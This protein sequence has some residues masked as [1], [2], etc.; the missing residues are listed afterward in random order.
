MQNAG[1]SPVG[2]NVK[3]G[4]PPPNKTRNTGIRLS[5]SNNN[6]RKRLGEFGRVEAARERRDRGDERG[7]DRV[8]RQPRESAL[9]TRRQ[10]AVACVDVAIR[11]VLSHDDERVLELGDERALRRRIEADHRDDGAVYINKTP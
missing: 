9:V 3:R 11:V 7:G 1:P 2:R 6:R 8:V 4:S 10:R 5:K